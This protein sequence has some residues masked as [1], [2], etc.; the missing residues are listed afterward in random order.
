MNPHPPCISLC[1]SA[2]RWEDVRP[3]VDVTKC[4]DGASAEWCTEF[5][6]TVITSVS[7]LFVSALVHTATRIKEDKVASLPCP[8]ECA[9]DTPPTRLPTCNTNLKR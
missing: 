3:L 2:A 6:V 8:A 4:Y 1:H 9:L 7:E 5:T